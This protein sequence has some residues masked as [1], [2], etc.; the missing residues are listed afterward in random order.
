MNPPPYTPE[1]FVK[2]IC[3][4]RPLRANTLLH[5]SALVAHAPVSSN[6]FTPCGDSGRKPAAMT[7]A[8]T[9]FRSTIIAFP[10][11]LSVTAEHQC[12]DRQEQCLDPQQQC[13]HQP[14]AIDDVQHNAL[15]G[16]GVL[17]RNRFVVAG[18]GVDDAATTRR[19]PFETAFVERLQIDKNSPR[20]CNI[21]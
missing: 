14:H 11:N 15:T 5:C 21:L 19:H 4:A 10:L 18:V 6:A 3:C 9:S 16:A 2:L 13:M 20:S 1:K 12:L 8:T 17:C 7:A